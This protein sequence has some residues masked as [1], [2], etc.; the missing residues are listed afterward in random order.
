MG[1]VLTSAL[2]GCYGSKC[3]GKK[4]G[5]C[6]SCT[7]EDAELGDVADPPGDISFTEDDVLALV[8][9]TWTGDT[10]EV[11]VTPGTE[12]A[13]RYHVVHINTDD[14]HVPAEAPAE[15]S[16]M[17]VSVNI[18]GTLDA[19]FFTSYGVGVYE[20][21]LAVA[22]AKPKGD[23]YYGMPLAGTDFKD[24]PY[25]RESLAFAPDGLWM[26]KFNSDGPWRKVAL[27]TSEE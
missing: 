10:I 17:S 24:D 16:G 11:H 1:L 14:C 9:G 23:R 5:A 22:G 3:D 27:K 6:W 21:T 19:A 20:R 2:N 18:E 26:R 15:C 7:A 12:P 4:C 13:R 8:T 25:H